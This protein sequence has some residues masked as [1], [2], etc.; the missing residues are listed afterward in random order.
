MGYVRLTFSQQS[1]APSVLTWDFICPCTF[2]GKR[3]LFWV[4]IHIRI[5]I[6]MWVN[7][8][9]NLNSEPLI[10]MELL[11]L[12]FNSQNYFSRRIPQKLGHSRDTKFWN[13]ECCPRRLK[14]GWP[15]ECTASWREHQMGQIWILTAWATEWHNVWIGKRVS[16]WANGR[17]SDWI[18]ERNSVWYGKLVS[19][20]VSGWIS[21]RVTKWNNI[22]IGKWVSLWVSELIWE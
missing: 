22:W 19:L 5:H 4:L 7:W 18:T 10:K 17:I 13:T 2:P 21:D 15:P 1:I 11:K 8:T 16:L 3:I 20:W 9:F 6:N 14:D 12:L